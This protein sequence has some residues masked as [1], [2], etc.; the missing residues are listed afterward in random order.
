MV[1]VVV[2]DGAS[3]ELSVNSKNRRKMDIEIMQSPFL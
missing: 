2:A 1:D 3:F